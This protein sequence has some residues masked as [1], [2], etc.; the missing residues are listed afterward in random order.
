MDE[1]GHSHRIPHHRIHLLVDQG[2]G[3]GT[4]LRGVCEGL[5][6]GMGNDLSS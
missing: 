3:R 2:A 1:E 4:G 6:T 5:W